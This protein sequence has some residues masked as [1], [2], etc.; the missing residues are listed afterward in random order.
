M[1]RS[2][3]LVPSYPRA[4]RL[5]SG[6]AIAIGLALTTISAQ[7]P[8][9]N[10]NMVAGQDWPGG[11]PFLQRQNEPS[12]AASTRNPLHLLAGSNDYRTIDLPGLPGEDEDETGDAWLGLYKSVDGG[13]RWNSGL[14]PGYPQDQT[15]EGLA[16]PLKGYQAGADPVVRAGISGLMFYSGLVFDRQEN[17][18]SAIFVS[19][20]IDENNQEAGDPFTYLGTTLVAQSNGADGRFL[21]KPWMA[22]DLPRNGA[23]GK[24][25][26]PLPPRVR[27]NGKPRKPR[28]QKLE[29]GNIYVAYT[30]ITGDGDTLR[31]EIYMHVSEDCGKSWGKPRLIS[32]PLD[33][34]NQGATIAI[35]PSD[36]DVFVTW[37]RFGLSAGESDGIM[38]YR[39]PSAGKGNRAP[40]W[41][42]RFK[43]KAWQRDRDVFEHRKRRL[44]NEAAEL[45][46]FDQNTT[47]FRFRSNAYPTATVDD[48]GRLYVAW[49][50]RG[51]AQLRPD[52]V[53]GDARVV[54][55]T[56]TDGERF[57]Q[58]RAV[59]EDGQPGHQ[60][61]PTIAFAGGRLMLVYYDVRET[62]A[63]NFG[64]FVSDAGLSTRQTMDIRAAMGQK[65]GT[66]QFESSVKVS[67]YLMGFRSASG[68]L[69]QLQVNPP[70]LPMFRQG[71]V[72]FI[73]DYIDVTAAPMFVVGRNGKWQ[74]NSATSPT[75]PVFHAVWTD[76]RDVRP[77]LNGDWTQYTP[78]LS[79]ALG[80]T[81]LVDPTQTPPACVPGNAGSRN[82]NV[83]SSRITGGLVVG[84]PG[85]AKQL[86]PALQRAFVV[87]AQNTTAQTRSFRMSI[88][89]QPPGGRASFSQFPLPPY[90]S[91]SPAPVTSIDMTVPP[92]SMASRT[93][94]VTSSDP[95]AQLTVDVVE[96]AGPGGP[97]VSDG[98]AGRTVINP[99][100]ENPDVENPDV[101]NPDVENPDVENAEVYNPDIENPDVENPDVENPDIENP[102]V[103]NPD[104]ENVVVANPDIDNVNIG[105]PDIENPDIENPDIE[106]PDVENPD[107]ENGAIADIT[108]NVKNTGNTT[109]AFNVNLFL[110]SAGV[111]QGL[112]TQLVIYKTY[113]TPV[114][115]PNGCELRYETRNVLVT[116]IASPNFISSGTGAVPD[117]NDPSA[118][119]P[120]LFLAPNEVGRI[121]LRI[122]DNDTSNNVLI[123]NA[124]GELVSI[125]P[126][127]N[128][129]E[130]D[131][132]PGV[133]SQAVDSEDAQAGVT[134]PPIVTPTGSNLFFLQQP[135]ATAVN[136][137]IAPPVRVRVI[138][139]SGSALPGVSVTLS[140]NV[141]GV[142]LTGGSALTDETGVATFG[143]LQIG[144]PGQNYV[145]TASVGGG[146][147]ATASSAPF[148]VIAEAVN[149]DLSVTQSWTP[150]AVNTTSTVTLTVLNNGPAT[151]TN[152]VLTG[153]LPVGVDFVTVTDDNCSYNADLRMVSCQAGSL[154]PAGSRGFGVVVTPTVTGPLVITATAAGAEPDP[155]PAN[156]TSE[157]VTFVPAYAACASPTFAGPFLRTLNT[158]STGTLGTADFNEDS[159]PDVVFALSDGSFA[160]LL[161]NGEGGFLEPQYFEGSSPSAVITGDFNR[162]GH[163]DVVTL[164]ATQLAPPNAVELGVWLG[165]GAGNFPDREGD[166]VLPLAGAFA[167]ETADFNQD[168]RL[169]LVVSS[170]N[171]A[172]NAVAVLL[173]VG[174][175]TFGSPISVP[176]GPAPGNVVLDDF[177]RDGQIDIAV[178]N[179]G[180]PTVSVMH[181]DGAGGFAA[182]QTTTTPA[183]TLR[184]RQLNDVNGDGAPDLGVTTSPGGGVP[185]NLLLLLNDG[186]GFLPATEIIG[187]RGVGFATTGDLNGDGRSDLA[188]ILFQ[189]N[190]LVIMSGNGEGGF[191][192]SAS[193][194]TGSSQNQFAITDLNA[195]G[196]PDIVGTIRGGYYFLI[197]TCAGGEGSSADLHSALEG[198]ENG[199][200][201]DALVYQAIISN[202][203]PDTATDVRATF[204]VP[205]G[206]T[207]V[208]TTNECF[209]SYGTV[210][211]H[212]PAI[213]PEA[214]ASFSV[215]VRAFAAGLRA[216]RVMATA[217][218]ADP[219]AS[220]NVG[221]ANTEIAPG[222]ATFIVT[223]TA[224]AGLGTLRQ[225][226]QDS[227]LNAGSTN[228]IQFN[229]EGT[230]PFVIVPRT[231]LPAVN[232]PAVIDATTQP[233]Y[234]GVPVVQISG[235]STGGTG[236]IV[237][238]GNSTLRGLSMTNWSGSA[239]QLAAQGNNLV[240][241][242]YIGLA[243]AGTAAG[244]SQGINVVSSNNRVGGTTSAARN[245]ISGNSGNGVTVTGLVTGG[246]LSTTGSGTV[247]IGNY[248][249]TNASGSAAIPNGTGIRVSVA[250]V[251][252]GSPSAP[253]LIS[254]NTNIGINANATVA[255]PASTTV[256]AVPSNL[257][258]QSNLIGTN[259]AGTAAIANANGIVVSA[260]TGQIGGVIPG[261][262]NVV[263][264]ST[265]TGILVTY[266]TVAAGPTPVLVAQAGPF[267][268]QG[269]IV[270]LN[271][272]GSAAIGNGTTGISIGTSNQV[273]GG[274]S[275]GARNIV[276]GNLGAGIN[277]F[278]STTPPVANAGAVIQGNYVGIN[279]AGTAFGNGNSGILISSAS[280]VTIGGDAA[281]AGNVISGNGVVTVNAGINLNNTSGSTIAGNRI[282]TNPAGTFA[283]PNTGNG[284]NLVNSNSNVIGGTTPGSRNVISGNGTGTNF[285]AGINISGSSAG[286]QVAGN[287]IGTDVTGTVMMG[288]NTSGIS[289][290][291]PTTGTI[292]GGTTP[293]AGNVISGNGRNGLF[294]VGI[295]MF[296]SNDNIVQGNR[297]GTNAAGAAALPNANGGIEISDSSNILIGGTAAAARNVVSGNGSGTGQGGNAGDG[298]GIFGASGGVLVQGNVIGADATGSAPLPNQSDGIFVGA[299]GPGITIGDVL[300]GPP[301]PG[302]GN[303]IAFNGFAGVA[304]TTANGVAIRGNSIHSNTA[305]GID[306]SR[307][308]VTANDPGDGD[309]G[310]NAVQNF[311]VVGNAIDSGT[312]EGTLNSTA[313]AEFTIDLYA[314]PT[315]AADARQGRRYLGSGTASTNGDGN[316]TFEFT[317]LPATVGEFVTATATD[318]AGNTSE[319]SSC[320]SVQ[321]PS[322][323]FAVTNANDDGSGSLRAAIV[324][325]NGA[326]GHQ[327]I[328][329]NIP[330]AGAESPAVISVASPLPAITESVTIDATTQPGWDGQPVVQ[331]RSPSSTTGWVGLNLNSNL[332]VIRGL[333]ITNFGTGI[334]G[335]QT[336]TGHVIER[337][338]IG[339]TRSNGSGGGNGVGLDWRAGN[340]VIRQN[341]ISGNSGDGLSVILGA[342]NNTI[343]NNKVGVGTDGLTLVPNAGH[344]VLFFD[345]PADNLVEDSIIS[346]NGGFGISLA[347]NGESAPVTGTRI[348]GNVIGLDAAGSLLRHADEDWIG[349]D[350]VNFGPRIRGNMQGGINVESA[351]GTIVGEV[352]GSN[353]IS[354]NT[355]H[356]IRLTGTFGTPPEIQYNRIGTD[357]TGMLARGNT[358]AGVFVEGGA[359]NFTIGGPGGASGNLISGNLNDGIEI[360]SGHNINVFYNV[361][362]LG[363]DGITAIG[364]GHLQ[365]EGDL[366]CCHAGVSVNPGNAGIRVGGVAGLGNTISGNHTGVWVN[367]SPATRVEGNRIGLAH[368]ANAML[369]NDGDAGIALYEAIDPQVNGNNIAGNTGHAGIFI[370]GAT[371][372]AY[373]SNTIRNQAN[374]GI[375]V[376]L[377]GGGHH[378]ASNSIFDNGGLGIDLNW[379]GVSANDPGDTD[380]G[381]NGLQN[382]PVLTA[383]VNGL[384]ATTRVDVDLTSFANG[385]YTIQFF[386]N[387]SCDASGHGEGERLIST[388]TGHSAPA[389][390]QPFMSEEVPA[391]QFI[392]AIATDS[393]GNTSEFSACRLV[394]SP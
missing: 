367:A 170:S 319:F 294:G 225:A 343:Q 4:A 28:T 112:Q 346:G 137:P 48:S 56:S 394:I 239:I 8:G 351:P 154:L 36:G 155:I 35:D 245:V 247:V 13:Q 336:F 253:N 255:G 140:L 97:P 352:A 18:K 313:N 185:G 144:T 361:I 191:T 388:F 192:E 318:A 227:N 10:V 42:R 187:P 208:S 292:I 355:F 342:A 220:N 135:T 169:D 108:W 152:I 363:A 53:E 231:S 360:Y 240:E 121:T 241:G 58:P 11:D 345:G 216:N 260:G 236:L 194:L 72:P 90:T 5:L 270:G 272:S 249:G 214:A 167:V 377:S 386:A 385:Q 69:E 138:D 221:S 316:A 107:I 301:T 59:D 307:D 129:E 16:S 340:S 57:T 84:S 110:A 285:G 308:G 22:V 289:L 99:D 64:A 150:V 44:P 305:N 349:D 61:M 382:F 381:T 161:S 224:D 81:S 55:V 390:S 229:I 70:N 284:I 269:N 93:V 181:G 209:E 54:I 333:S 280:N 87:F 199:T 328:S 297:I 139:N 133:S 131:V 230:A 287:Y 380:G 102:D 371:G 356:G 193:Y 20:L 298:I 276:A 378:F 330:G 23:R 31:A 262:G 364:N 334:L 212:I 211:C 286:N 122:I 80:P 244:N 235:L 375:I 184:L 348:R 278:S 19:R 109:A 323:S 201:G 383:A 242:N 174:N 47:N 251:T 195:D 156:N 173:G 62:R 52:A 41:A 160:L 315:C 159:Y 362:G 103:E 76:N 277:L 182:P 162:D 332:V 243:P 88:G 327:Q 117:P 392:T 136:T 95:D 264:G 168:N 82:Q 189:E 145:L 190:R 226:I 89:G 393:Q 326:E 75:P 125:D 233:G 128:P 250:D 341:V 34:V 387:T 203:G 312:V 331:L 296:G 279:A 94:Y 222:P 321:A 91:S 2:A 111:P 132:T 263:S 15:P 354:G 210:Q 171:A 344:G 12:I 124:K 271:A 51:F 83:Y 86:S 65:G 217:S 71:T 78:P 329:F 261:E 248:I 204:I 153:T 338:I 347:S 26:I 368:T 302:A 238:A 223:S 37:R 183:N 389:T 379:D 1:R 290:N 158:T 77:P 370:Y 359:S 274:T 317:L 92:R 32:D 237:N 350:L 339:T 186:A 299:T 30:S 149:A 322:S 96:I 265:F 14:I 254:G 267:T 106:N 232:V 200:V 234:D 291:S 157:E 175:G 39:V 127:F 24:C 256:L 115:A 314:S 281:G 353:T 98:L 257:L 369:P 79:P 25:E 306:L 134:D 275:A 126:L 335:F 293:S 164:N 116:N 252:I 213:S 45:D 205:S 384:G 325:A 172:D 33:R 228:S 29:I 259:A 219:D 38:V 309:T 303:V 366:G 218:E 17:G 373:Q 372:G 118:K 176:S 311:P 142:V 266:N 120:T 43:G 148:N 365:I 202:A 3:P 246:V 7:I 320:V 304:L 207:F 206:M 74:Y 196:K 49:S 357:P 21:D 295:N 63:Q 151:A 374:A 165:D 60:L 324:A 288:N 104:I 283:I 66:P 119:N 198:P 376:A 123:R 282:G 9:R 143:A 27:K 180:V 358:N 179:I 146:I 85:N 46:Q 73:G 130:N 105:N 40:S 258:V 268:I 178:N 50:E 67:D 391:G 197:N 113:V 100:V 177:N 337:N 114:T 166:I 147:P 6:I 188:A 141:P 300:P 273:V 101:E 310:P 68:P 163:A 215:T